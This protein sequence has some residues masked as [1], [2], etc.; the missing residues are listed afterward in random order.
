[1]RLDVTTDVGTEWAPS[2]LVSFS[3]GKAGETENAEPATVQP[4][5]WSSD[6][7]IGDLV[8]VPSQSKH[9]KVGIRVVMALGRDPGDCTLDE[10]AECI[11]ARRQ[12]RFLQNETLRLPIPLY[13]ACL[14]VPCEPD[15]TCDILGRCIRSDIDALECAKLG[16]AACEPEVEESSSDGG[17]GQR[18]MGGATTTGEILDASTTTTGANGG[19]GGVGGNGM[20]GN[21]GV[22]GTPG[23]TGGVGGTA[24]TGGTEG[25]SEC[26]GRL[27]RMHSGCKLGVHRSAVHGSGQ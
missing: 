17:A 19:V 1:M 25:S 10:P 27:Q 15:T 5:A 21:G 2:A 14:G 26:R 24:A 6:G 3:F 13:A 8:V 22:G 23:G 16:G 18:G 20:G 12:L 4:G 9:A 11:I 7:Q